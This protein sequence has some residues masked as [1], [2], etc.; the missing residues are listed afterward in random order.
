[1]SYKNAMAGLPMGG[2]KAVILADRD[3]TK[4]PEM[5][6]A[7]GRA[8][9]A[10]GGRYVTAEDVG[11]SEADMV[12][13]GMP[14]DRIAVHY[15]GIE[16][17][18]FRPAERAAAKAT[19]GVS[20]PLLLAAGNLVPV[21]RHAL[22]VEA[23]ALLP[24]ATL[25]IAGDGRERA[26]LQM[27]VDARGVGERVRLLGGVAH[28]NMPALMAAADVFVHA[29]AS[30]GLANVWVEALASGTPVVTTR[31]GGA[32]EVVDRPAAGRLVDDARPE[33][34][35]AAIADVLAHP[36]AAADTRAAAL[37]FDWASNT[38]QLYSHLAGL[39]RKG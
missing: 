6:A 35:A 24:D 22:L 3:R 39:A 12:A 33:G 7:F 21:K 18:H 14:A 38:A 15:T 25:L 4:T 11:M 13:M 37:R 2:G 10:L 23:L 28:D 16:L 34:F 27:L 32:A 29:A 8:I 26:A 9:E 19:L 36:P 20:G 17:G 1:M 30:E 31:V 5:L